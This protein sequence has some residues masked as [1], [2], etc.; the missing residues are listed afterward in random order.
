MTLDEC[1]K[2]IPADT[3]GLAAITAGLVQCSPA[4]LAPP[5]TTPNQHGKGG[6]DLQRVVR[7]GLLRHRTG[8]VRRRHALSNLLL[9]ACML[10]PFACTSRAL[11]DD[12]ISIVTPVRSNSRFEKVDFLSR[13]GAAVARNVDG[14]VL[15]VDIATGLSLRQL[16]KKGTFATVPNE[17]TIITFSSDGTL[18]QLDLTTGRTV[19]SF[20]EVKSP[21]FL[22]VSANGKTVFAGEETSSGRFLQQRVGEVAKFIDLRSGTVKATIEG[23]FWSG[24]LSP[25]G[26]VAATDTRIGQKVYGVQLWD[27]ATGRELGRLAGHNEEVTSIAFSS[28]GK[29]LV[30]GSRDRTARIWDVESGRQ[31]VQ[32]AGHRDS[33]HA[34]AFA[35]DGEKVLTAS[36]DKTARLWSST[37]GELLFEFRTNDQVVT[38]AFSADGQLIL[39]G[40]NDSTLHLYSSSTGREL[41]QLPGN[42]DNVPVN[43]IALSKSGFLG[44]ANADASIRLWDLTSG[45]QI[46]VLQGHEGAVQSLEWSADGKMLLSGGL[47]GTL[48]LWD[49]AS[50]ALLRTSAKVEPIKAIYFANGDRG[51]LSLSGNQVRT[52]D[53]STLRE[54]SRLKI[55]GAASL[56]YSAAKGRVFVGFNRKIAGSNDGRILSLDSDLSLKASFDVEKTKAAKTS[57]F[58]AFTEDSE[59]SAVA[60]PDGSVIAASNA[61]VARLLNFSNGREISELGIGSFSSSSFSTQGSRLFAGDSV[62]GVSAWDL[63]SQR[64]AVTYKGHQDVVTAVRASSDMRFLITGALDGT[65]RIW[66][67]ATGHEIATLIALRNGEWLTVTPE[68]YFDA[69]SRQAAENLHAVRGLEV[70]SIDQFRDALYR[71]DLVKAKLAGD[72]D[73]L[74]KAAAAKLDLNRAVESG[75]APTVAITSPANASSVAKGEVSFEATVSDQGGG[76]GRI[77]WRLNGQPVGIENR[78]FQRIQDGVSGGTSPAGAAVKIS[79]RIV[80][81]ADDNVIEVVAYNTKGLVASQP[82]RITIKAVGTAVTAKPRLFV[83]AV[84]VNDYFDGRL[85]LNYAAPDARSIAASFEKAGKGLYESVKTVTALDG[86]ATRPNLEKV[87]SRLALEVKTSDVFVLFV[88]GHGRTVDGHYY[89]LP[90]DFKYRDQNS[91]AESGLSQEQWQK[92]ITTVQARRSVL[93]YDTCESGSVTADP[94]VSASNTRGLQRVEEQAVAYDKLRDATGKTILAASTDTQ[95]ALEGYRGH[96]VFSYVVMEALDKAQTNAS[97]L[98]EVTGLI[99]YVD[100]KVPEISFQAFKQR[101]IPQNKLTGS[102]FAI[103]RPAMTLG[104]GGGDTPSTNNKKPNASAAELI[105][106]PGISSPKPT[107]VIIAR[108]DVFEAVGGRGARVEQLPPGTL[109]SLVRSDQGWVLIAREGRSIGYVVEDKLART[110]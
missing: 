65:T 100:D 56:A 38:G 24:A 4:S 94:V 66:E 95:P 84:G 74:L 36:G 109:V 21:G 45:R 97:G 49:R 53:T 19:R 85:K 23:P 70:F 3:N 96:G 6:I 29:R 64:I 67:Q 14:T 18:E 20:P 102:N 48:R 31:I 73:G 83:L 55:E 68:G 44:T 89:F 40:G 80:L 110:Q 39:I 104:P 15:L 75:R 76:V 43:A 37:T 42:V 99:S 17:P 103:G 26:R 82:A 33:V 61:E 5:A 101:Q 92:W 35:P 7:T 50:G 1:L 9:I 62:G 98:I 8:A 28:D 91:Y 12:A 51:I 47:D 69:S 90:Q 105:P 27:T 79:Q 54:R 32:L 87:F 63:Q 2:P 34:V 59:W 78:G 93:I 41:K 107:H 108:A 10:S 106:D 16:S 25:D 46:R 13:G 30:T 81:D 60:S 88:A 77:E 57:T 71:P 58:L 86:D 52:W 22:A 11:G 72:P